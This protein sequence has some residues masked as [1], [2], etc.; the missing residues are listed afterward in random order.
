MNDL[1]LLLQAGST[2]ALSGLIWFVQVVHYPLFA[3]VGRDDFPELRTRAR[4]AHGLGRRTAHGL[5]RARRGLVARESAGRMRSNAA[6]ARLRVS[7]LDLGFHRRCS[8]SRHTAAWQVTSPR[9][10]TVA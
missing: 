1:V 8:R 7:A 9:M 3:A 5:G 6:S 4:Q 2:L 10:T